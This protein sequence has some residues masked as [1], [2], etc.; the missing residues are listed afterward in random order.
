MQALSCSIDLSHLHFDIILESLLKLGDDPNDRV[1]RI[2]KLLSN[3]EVDVANHAGQ[4][5]QS[6]DIRLFEEGLGHIGV[7]LSRGID[8]STQ[9]LRVV[10]WVL[11]VD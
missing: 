2:F 8:K 7:K 3:F 10:Q 4:V 9:T 11:Q 1:V 5:V 6:F